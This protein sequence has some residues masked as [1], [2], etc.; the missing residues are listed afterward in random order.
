VGEIHCLDDLPSGTDAVILCTGYKASFPFLEPEL[1]KRALNHRDRFHHMLALEIGPTLAFI[2]YSRP[3]RTICSLL[4]PA[5]DGQP[6]LVRHISAERTQNGQGLRRT[7]FS[8][9]FQALAQTCIIS[10]SQN[11]LSCETHWLLPPFADL[12][13]YH[14][15][16]HARVMR[17]ALSGA[18]YR[19]AGQDDEG[20]AIKENA[21]TAVSAHPLPRHSRQPRRALYLKLVAGFFCSTSSD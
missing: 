6:R 4:G 3:V 2:G 18:Q 5:L 16:T 12:K 10:S 13:R 11:G 7:I 20:S 19:F 8:S 9:R 21:W 14:P 17:S 15:H 1:N